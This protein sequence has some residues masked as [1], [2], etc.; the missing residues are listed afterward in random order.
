MSR[1]LVMRRAVL[2]T[3]ILSL[4]WPLAS[5]SQMAETPSGW[6]LRRVWLTDRDQLPIG[7][8]TSVPR[9]EFER[10][11]AATE[12]HVATSPSVAMHALKV[13]LRWREGQLLGDGAIDLSLVRPEPALLRLDPWSLSL[14][15]RPTLGG[16]PAVIAV[17]EAASGLDVL[18]R[19][20]GRQQLLFEAGIKAW[21]TP[22][23]YEFMLEFPPIPLIQVELWLP[24]H[25]RPEVVESRFDVQQLSDLDTAGWRGWRCHLGSSSASRLSI[26]I[27]PAEVPLPRPPTLVDIQSVY[28]LS[29]S[30]AEVQWQVDASG[31]APRSELLFQVS[32]GWELT[33]IAD[34]P[35]GQPVTWRRLPAPRSDL[36]A[37]ELPHRR[38]EM[39]SLRIR[40]RWLGADLD[41]PQAGGTEVRLGGFWPVQVQR[42]HE[43]ITL[44]LERP[45]RLV[46]LSA[47]DYQVLAWNVPE[48]DEPSAARRFTF[49]PAR[50]EGPWARERPVIRVAAEEPVPSG[51]LEQWLHVEPTVAS[52]SAQLRLHAPGGAR[53]G[54]VRLPPGWELVDLS[55]LDGGGAAL[56]GVHVSLRG[57]VLTFQSVTA[58]TEVVIDTQLRRELDWAGEQSMSL[59]LPQVEPLGV[60]TWRS[61]WAVTLARSRTGSE[62]VPLVAAKFSDGAE[63]WTFP[64]ERGPWRSVAP[65]PDFAWQ[66]RGP[67]PSR[68]LEL[69]LLPPRF[70]GM[71][72]TFVEME[73]GACRLRYRLSAKPLTGQSEIVA[74]E[75]SEPPPAALAWRIAEGANAIVALR[76]LDDTHA[77][78]LLARPI[79]GTLELV[80]EAEWSAS[81]PIPLLHWPFTSTGEL[82][83]QG[84]SLGQLALSHLGWLTPLPSPHG[85]VRRWRYDRQTRGVAIRNLATVD[86]KLPTPVNTGRLSWDWR[87]REGLLARWWLPQ[88]LPERL[89][90]RL[91]HGEIVRIRSGLSDVPWQRLGDKY[92]VEVAGETAGV[93]L[94]W[95]V[96]VHGQLLLHALLTRPIWEQTELRAAGGEELHSDL[97][98]LVS[99]AAWQPV[100]HEHYFLRYNV[101]TTDHVWGLTWAGVYVAS[102]AVGLGLIASFYMPRGLGVGVALAILIMAVCLMTQSSGVVATGSLVTAALAGGCLVWLW[103]WLPRLRAVRA[104]ATLLLTLWLAF[105]SSAQTDSQIVTVYLI[106]GSSANAQDAIVLIDSDLWQQIKRR[107]L[108]AFRAIFPCQVVH[109]GRMLDGRWRMVSQVVLYI[110]TA[111]ARWPLRLTAGQRLVRLSVD[112]QLREPMLDNGQAWLE[113]L[114]PGEFHCEMVWETAAT[115][116]PAE[117]SCS[118]FVAPVHSVNLI[119]GATHANWKFSPPAAVVS[120]TREGLEAYLPPR[121]D[122][123]AIRRA[124]PPGRAQSRA[125]Q[126]VALSPAGPSLRS[127]WMVSTIE[128]QVSE[129]SAAWPPGWQVKTIEVSA[130]SVRATA[131]RLASWRLE[132]VP[133]AGQRLVLG[134]AEP[135]AGEFR[136][137]IEAIGQFPSRFLLPIPLDTSLAIGAVVAASVATR[138]PLEWQLHLPRALDGLINEELLILRGDRVEWE[139]EGANEL[140]PQPALF[141]TNRNPL[142]RKVYRRTALNQPLQVRLVPTAEIATIKQSVTLAP[143][144]HEWLMEAD[145][146][147]QTT[148]GIAAPVVIR[149]PDKGMRLEE[150][151]GPRLAAWH[152]H[153]GSYTVWLS[154]GSAEESIT[155]IKLRS[156]V[157]PD[158]PADRPDEAELLEW[159]CKIE[160][161]PTLTKAAWREPALERGPGSAGGTLRRFLS[162]DE[163]SWRFVAEAS[164]TPPVAGPLYLR[165]R[166]WPEEAGFKW[167][168]DQPLAVALESEGAGKWQVRLATL[169][170]LSWFRL[171]T[172]W[173]TTANPV[174]PL[175]ELAIADRPLTDQIE[176]G[177]GVAWETSDK[178]SGEKQVRRQLPPAEV[179]RQTSE[180]QSLPV[181]TN[182]Q[183][184]VLP[185]SRQQLPLEWLA[186]PAVAAVLLRWYR[187]WLVRTATVS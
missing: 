60:R 69:R 174:V 105:P 110:D 73:G 134:F 54:Q 15:K 52:L 163:V 144:G 171:M 143:R 58:W 115:E 30:G 22:L 38:G 162:A 49:A 24:G 43:S 86:S 64:E 160:P 102:V 78:I 94:T 141:R 172:S 97:P 31:W 103:P 20:P 118:S 40:G 104:A 25:L 34:F 7:N 186:V 129:W 67:E 100:P 166:H 63:V 61:R 116:P 47:G 37:V 113:F 26:R 137:L 159:C 184:V 175:P 13:R 1:A 35:N 125:I 46:H 83:L 135:V 87:E 183:P 124:P 12:R 106:P 85:G 151:T 84:D 70:F 36:V 121:A 187:W 136:V 132:P 181:E 57:N 127:L 111:P 138:Q 148:P 32:D 50:P 53:Q 2:M 62:A 185:A 179:D 170:P 27:R 167:E 42:C 133:A 28:A 68:R 91:S 149:P 56:G 41:N 74:L 17:A 80:G 109:S 98:G 14:T 128:G 45:L 130:A 122:L 165:I 79:Q 164:L 146:Q 145:V 120:L 157:K 147:I 8:W 9:P 39:A 123:W 76:R 101:G 140:V 23:G 6:K 21:P 119:L 88:P 95:R 117:L 51:S 178:T 10:T 108:P 152:E 44:R 89:S 155:N 180:V 29:A 93:E 92:T 114:E 16:A 18:V 55:V 48:S 90:F 75:F 81:Q 3:A 65:V 173:P 5:V 4:T 154:P 177:P 169:E 112:G 150:L 66:A 71:V 126:E 82:W 176:T 156:W 161:R 59:I 19:R 99:T 168:S 139:V 153:Q 158:H 142:S 77:E 33:E 182:R 72:Q 131:P 107:S 96:P 11:W